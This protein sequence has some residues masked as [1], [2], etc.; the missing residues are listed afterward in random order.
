MT[1]PLV[2]L[3]ELELALEALLE[4]DD[5]LLELVELL[6]VELEL[7]ELDEDEL[8]FG[9]PPH[10]TSVAVANATTINLKCFINKPHL[11][12]ESAAIASEYCERVFCSFIRLTKLL[13]R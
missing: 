2:L 4:L 13:S 8:A 7:E 3:E 9:S 12:K 6:L 10:A 11:V 1:T 5:E